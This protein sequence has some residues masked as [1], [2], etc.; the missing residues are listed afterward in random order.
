VA[1]TKESAAT[2]G[3]DIMPARREQPM[4]RSADDTGREF[5]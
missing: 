3:I 2:T 1:T 5:M 4:A